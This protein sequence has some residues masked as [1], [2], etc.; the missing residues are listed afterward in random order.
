[1]KANI[2]KN[3]VIISGIAGVGKT[4]VVVRALQESDSVWVS[5]PSETQIDS[6]K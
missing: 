6:L 5:G 1:M 3:T 4:D 2:L